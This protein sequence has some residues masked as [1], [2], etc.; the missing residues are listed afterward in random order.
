MRGYFLAMEGGDSKGKGTQ[1]L[2]LVDRLRRAGERV[3]SL[4]FPQYGQTPFAD[5]LK[6]LLDQKI[7][8][9]EAV[10]GPYAAG[11]MS[12][13]Y[14]ADRWTRRDEIL[15][16][17]EEGGHVVSNRWVETNKAHQAAK[18]PAA[19]V[20]RV[21][22]LIDRLEYGYLGLPRADVNFLLTAETET[23]LR[24]LSRRQGE[25][26]AHEAN[27][28]Y[29]Q[30]VQELFEK[31][32]A[33]DPGRWAVIWC[34]DGRGGMLPQEEIHEKIWSIVEAMLHRR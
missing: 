8:S 1:S 6:D 31:L 34:D 22:H 28:Q 21:F 2:L 29:Q 32:A 3:L 13:L 11:L 20:P 17:M 7:T 33:S 14:A 9:A 4:D 26:D 23:S 18:F 19:E 15:R 5:F 12:A 30:R 16:T 27:P 25:G 10:H 24:L